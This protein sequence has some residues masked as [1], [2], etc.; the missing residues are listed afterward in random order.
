MKTW[1]EM[2]RTE[3]K[4]ILCKD[5]L[6][7]IKQ[8]RLT[9]NWGFYINGIYRLPEILGREKFDEPV[10]P[11][12]C[13]V[14]EK[15]CEVCARGAL[16]LSRIRLFNSVEWED[17]KSFGGIGIVQEHTT[18]ILSEAFSPEELLAIEAAFEARNDEDNDAYIGEDEEYSQDCIGFGLEYEHPDD[19]LVAIM[20]NI[21]EN[22]GDFLGYK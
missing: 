4:V 5:V 7:R 20:E 22:N 19:R 10:T 3:R 15:H 17:L 18:D 12:D 6:A 2:S 16:L 8:E 1:E 14:I 21:I 9:V 11:D 13:L